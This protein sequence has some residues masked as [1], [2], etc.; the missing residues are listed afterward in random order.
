[1]CYLAL[2][3]MTEELKL[4]TNTAPKLPNERPSTFRYSS[5]SYL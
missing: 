1:M 3:T 5:R 2:I 4:Y